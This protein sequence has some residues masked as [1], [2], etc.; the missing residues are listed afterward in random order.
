MPERDD[1]HALSLRKTAKIRDR[2]ARHAIDRVEVVD[3][4]RSANVWLD[5]DQRA[6]AI[7]KMGQNISLASR[8]TGFN[9]QLMQKDTSGLKEF[10]GIID[11]ATEDEE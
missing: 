5:E 6:L 11:E 9:I 8:L 3:E 10:E 1:A 2:N 7:G 4:S